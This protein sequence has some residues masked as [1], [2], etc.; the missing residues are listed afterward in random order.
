[1][2]HFKEQLGLQGQ[3]SDY[4]DKKKRLNWRERAG[5]HL[6]SVTVQIPSAPRKVGILKVSLSADGILGNFG[7][8][9]PL[10]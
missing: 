10:T 4:H 5:V 7:D 6:P 3:I 8:P 1:M 9:G 2:L